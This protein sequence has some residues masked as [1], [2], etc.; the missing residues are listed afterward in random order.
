M[1]S[2]IHAG[3]GLSLHPKQMFDRGYVI[4]IS[5]GIEYTAHGARPGHI[6]YVKVIC[7]VE[8]KSVQA[9]MF[10]NSGA[11]DVNMQKQG[12]L[13][14][15]SDYRIIAREWPGDINSRIWIP[16]VP[17][18]WGKGVDGGDILDAV[19]EPVRLNHG[20]QHVQF[21]QVMSRLIGDHQFCDDPNIREHGY[22]PPELTNPKDVWGVGRH[23][24]WEHI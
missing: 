3:Q 21:V 24:L 4:C 8:G 19:G 16:T 15:L 13:R 10:A 18:G 14:E 7:D 1:T 22:K 12:G 5:R 9:G 6:I 11:E 23:G 20:S 2:T 17:N